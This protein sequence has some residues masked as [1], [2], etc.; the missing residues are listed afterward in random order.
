MAVC[1]V[2][3]QAIASKLVNMRVRILQVGSAKPHLQSEAVAVFGLCLANNIR[4]EPK[5]I[6]REQNHMAD[7]ISRI[8][9]H[10][11]W[12]LDSTMFKV[13][14]DLWGPHTVDRF[15][16]HYNAQL[17]RFNSQYACPG[18]ECSGFLYCRLGWGK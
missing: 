15:A 7:Y 6:P 10:D 2:V 18:S 12:S 14:D 16:T 17:E 4:L 5:W 11:D 3:L 9:D 8:V 13:L 1:R